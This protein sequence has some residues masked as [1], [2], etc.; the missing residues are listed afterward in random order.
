MDLLLYSVMI[1]RCQL[2]KNVMTNDTDEGTIIRREST[3]FKEL[4]L[5]LRPNL[6]HSML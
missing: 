4:D 5:Y 3:L 1:S 2:M 6:V